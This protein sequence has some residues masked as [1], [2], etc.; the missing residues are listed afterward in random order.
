MLF[1][2]YKVNFIL[3]LEKFSMKKLALLTTVYDQIQ[4]LASPQSVTANKATIAPKAKVARNAKVASNAKVAPNTEVSSTAQN[5][6]DVVS[7]G[8]SSDHK[9]AKTR[10][11]RSVWDYLFGISANEVESE[12]NSHF[13][14]LTSNVEDEFVLE[15]SIS[16]KIIN[17]LNEESAEITRLKQIQDRMVQKMNLDLLFNNE[18]WLQKNIFFHSKEQ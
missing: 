10:S 3:T 13:E 12:M 16:N 17:L 18:A 4:T 1:K 8:H 15:R 5:L 11:R 9:K 14:E 2:T 6:P 7:R